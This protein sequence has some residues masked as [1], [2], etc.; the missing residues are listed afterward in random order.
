MLRS[1]FTMYLS[2]VYTSVRT[3]TYSY[4]YTYTYL[5]TFDLCC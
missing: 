4:T 5:R 3:R 2:V 1:H